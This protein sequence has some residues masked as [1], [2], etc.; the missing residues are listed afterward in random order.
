M[1][2]VVFQN[3]MDMIGCDNMVQHHFRTPNGCL[4]GNE[5]EI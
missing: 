4:G 1:I 2:A 5:G 3:Q